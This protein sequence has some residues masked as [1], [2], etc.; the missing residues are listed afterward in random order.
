VIADC[1]VD[2]GFI[3]VREH[4]Q[5]SRTKQMATVSRFGRTD[6]KDSSSQGAGDCCIFAHAFDGYGH[7]RAALKRYSLRDVPGRLGTTTS[8]MPRSLVRPGS[9]ELVMLHSCEKAVHA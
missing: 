7:Q 9:A 1:P 2:V 6:R 5:C 8:G 3:V 4:F